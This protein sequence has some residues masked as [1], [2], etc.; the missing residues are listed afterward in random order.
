MYIIQEPVDIPAGTGRISEF[1][2]CRGVTGGGGAGQNAR[3]STPGAGNTCKHARVIYPPGNLQS[4]QNC[5][6][7][8]TNA[9]QFCQ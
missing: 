5:T 3:A 8:K 4:K 1:V 9:K 2:F 7:R 6:N